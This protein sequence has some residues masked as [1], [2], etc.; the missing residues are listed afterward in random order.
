LD[1]ELSP[2]WGFSV[3]DL[4]DWGVSMFDDLCLLQ[5]LERAG[6]PQRGDSSQQWA[7]PIDVSSR[8][9]SALKGRKKEVNV[10][11]FSPRWGFG[12]FCEYRISD[13][14]VSA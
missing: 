8:E 5:L 2:R 6:K 3:Y 9:M 10:M 11:G 7:P 1:Y 12:F 14:S 13:S 4:S